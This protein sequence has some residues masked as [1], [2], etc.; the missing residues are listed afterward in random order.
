MSNHQ[1]TSL[2]IKCLDIQYGL[3]T[4]QLWKELY[5]NMLINGLYVLWYYFIPRKWLLLMDDIMT[6]WTNRQWWSWF[7]LV[8]QLWIAENHCEPP[9][10]SNLTQDHKFAK[11]AGK[12]WEERSR[13]NCSPR[14]YGADGGKKPGAHYSMSFLAI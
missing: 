3:K 14:K 10:I 8:Q 7:I 9:L 2:T 11:E 6:V 12:D 4:L 1:W 13:W 5:P